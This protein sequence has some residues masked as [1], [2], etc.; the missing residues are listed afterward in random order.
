M[1]APREILCKFR[2][3]LSL[4]RRNLGNLGNLRPPL[5]LNFRNPNIEA[6][7]APREIL[8]KFRPT[9][10]LPSRNLGN[11]GNLRPPLRLNLSL[12]HI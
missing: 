1:R 4:P 10:S 8:G 9:L 3:T 6:M 7:R 12:I 11:L 2:P 5:R